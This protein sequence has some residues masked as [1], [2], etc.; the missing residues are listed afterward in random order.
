MSA[1]LFQPP[2]FFFFGVSKKKKMRRWRWKQPKRRLWRMKRGCFEEAAR[3]AGTKCA[4]LVLP[5]RCSKKKKSFWQLVGSL[6]K[7]QTAVLTLLH[8]ACRFV[9]LLFPLPLVQR[10]SITTM[11]A[12]AEIGAGQV[13]TQH[14]LAKAKYTVSGS[15]CR[16]APTRFLFLLYRQRHVFFFFARERKRRCGV[17]SVGTC[18]SAIPS[19]SKKMGG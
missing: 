3:L 6:V 15:G 2:I 1:N 13:V 14:A 18:A 11:G 4:G 12:A 5:R 9:L 19:A 16:Y 8:S 17:E 10:F 7:K